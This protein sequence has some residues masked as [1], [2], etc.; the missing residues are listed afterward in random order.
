M[1]E[2]GDPLSIPL[3]YPR[4]LFSSPQPGQCI[5]HFVG[6][7]NGAGPECFCVAGPGG[8]QD[9]AVYDAISGAVQTGP[10]VF[11]ILA[12]LRYAGTTGDSAW[13]SANMPKIRAMMGFLDA[14]FDPSVGL[15]NAPGSLQID[16]FIRQNY[17]ADS[18]AMGVLLCE[19]F[20]DAEAS[21]GNATGA[22][23]YTSRASAL[24]AAMNTYLLDPATSDHYCTQSNPNGAGGVDVCARDFVDYGKSA[25]FDVQRVP[26]GI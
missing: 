23:F 26:R 18:N 3:P 24:R 2:L 16:V 7:C 10:N 22:A 8:V 13:L 5:H 9:C 21:L 17:T 12:A 11:T 14:R 1:L 4:T 19:L 15:Y 20:A 6:D 25:F